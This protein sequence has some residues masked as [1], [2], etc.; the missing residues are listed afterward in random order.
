MRKKEVWLVLIQ[1]FHSLKVA[2][3]QTVF[4]LDLSFKNVPNYS[5]EPFS[6]KVQDSDSAHFLEDGKNFLRSSYL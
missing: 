2:Q 5:T 3:S 1:T 6:L 4:S